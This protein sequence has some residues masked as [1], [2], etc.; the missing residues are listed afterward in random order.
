MVFRKPQSSSSLL[1]TDEELFSSFAT[2]FRCMFQSL[3]VLLAVLL[4]GHLISPFG[5][6]VTFEGADDHRRQ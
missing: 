3:L 4:G 5:S 2:Q 6:W 1:L